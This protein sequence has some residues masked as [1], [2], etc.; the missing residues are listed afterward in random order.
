MVRPPL[1]DSLLAGGLFVLA[2]I[3]AAFAADDPHRLIA[4]VFALPLTLPV[5][6][7]RIYPVP[8]FA[9]V[10][11][12]F[13]MQTLL[14]VPDNAQVTTT[15]VWIATAYTLASCC[16][17][18][19]AVL[20]VLIPTLAMLAIMLRQDDHSPSDGLVILAVLTAAPWVI[21]RIVRTTSMRTRQLI[22][23]AARAEIESE[24]RARQV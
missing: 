8:V 1:L 2:E 18:R 21:G 14:G 16:E 5:A 11:A 20:G 12:A 17:L 10:M 4:A 24:E 22:T 15:L 6:Y 3:E 9:I 19:P 23:E 13:A 7:R